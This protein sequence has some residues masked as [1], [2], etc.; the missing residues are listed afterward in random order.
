[1]PVR[2]MPRQIMEEKSTTWVDIFDFFAGINHLI[3]F[4]A[5]VQEFYWVS[6]RDGFAH[7]YR[8]DYSG[9]LL[10]AVT[11]GKWEVS[12]VHHIDPKTKKV[13]FTS[14]EASPLERQLFV[15]DVDGKNKRRLN[16]R[17]G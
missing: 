9:K 16:H 15:A 14:T 4:P 12:Y 11:S 1:M 5:G 13:Y 7:L 2:V 8:Y 17:T 6:D 10:N 3:Y